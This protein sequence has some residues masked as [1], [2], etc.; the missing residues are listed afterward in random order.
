MV[1]APV[2]VVGTAREDELPPPNDALPLLTLYVHV[3]PVAGSVQVAACAVS[4]AIVAA[5]A[6]IAMIVFFIV[7]FLIIYCEFTHGGADTVFS[8]IPV[9]WNQHFRHGHRLRIYEIGQTPH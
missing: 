1:N 4:A 2:V 7:T 8:L 3:M 6:A 5:I 9:E